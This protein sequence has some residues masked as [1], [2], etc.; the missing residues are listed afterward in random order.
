MARAALTKTTALGAY[1]T[2]SAGAADLTMTAADASEKNSFTCTG[3]DLVIAHN[4]GAVERTITISSVADPYN[5]T[6]DI[7]AYALGAGEY[8]VFGPFKVR[9]W[10]Q[11]DGKIYLEA[12]HAEVKFGVVAL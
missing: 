7:T 9:G 1:G 10:Q 3:N 4:T 2:Y 11:S 6:G 5:R 12:N 8:A